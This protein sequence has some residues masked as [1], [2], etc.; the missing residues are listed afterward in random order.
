MIALHGASNYPGAQFYQECAQINVVG[1]TG[2]KTPSNTVSFPG[3]YS[4]RII[5]RAVQTLKD[6]MKL[7]HLPICRAAT[8]ESSSPSTGPRSPTTRFPALPSSP[9]KRGEGVLGVGCLGWDVMGVSVW[10]GRWWH[11]IFLCINLLYPPLFVEAA[12]LWVTELK[13]CDT[14]PALFCGT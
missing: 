4:V 7:T 5:P 8:P 1:G 10:R 2:S 12:C 14:V 9:A 11:L 3:A 6:R 13:R